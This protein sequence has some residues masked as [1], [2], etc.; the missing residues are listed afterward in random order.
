M[1]NI[2]TLERLKNRFD[3]IKERTS[4]LEY[5]SMEMKKKKKEEEEKENKK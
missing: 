3:E 5:Q 1:Q 2:N 4:Q